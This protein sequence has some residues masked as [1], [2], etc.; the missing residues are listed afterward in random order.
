MCVCVCVCVCVWWCASGVCR[1]RGCAWLECLE[2]DHVDGFSG[3]SRNVIFFQSHPEGVTCYREYSSR[4][5]Q[6]NDQHPYT[7]RSGEPIRA[8]ELKKKKNR[9]HPERVCIAVYELRG[10]STRLATAFK[11]EF[12]T[13]FTILNM[14]M[15]HSLFNVTNLLP[16]N[17]VN[18]SDHFH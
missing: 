1:G 18:W 3:I 9:P 12:H 17:L 4:M 13:L 7:P 2:V 14:N 10:V 11:S 6:G 5:D 15:F 16:Y 8:Q